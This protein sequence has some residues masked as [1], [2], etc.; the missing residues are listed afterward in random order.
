MALGWV[1][2]SMCVL[3]WNVGIARLVPMSSVR[4]TLVC[5]YCRVESYVHCGFK[6]LTCSYC[7]WNIHIMLLLVWHVNITNLGSMHNVLIMQVLIS[8]VF[9]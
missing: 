5:G 9:H 8:C 1:M 4:L 2:G 3:V 7:N 6:Y